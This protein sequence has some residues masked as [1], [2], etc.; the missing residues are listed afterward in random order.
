M[1]IVSFTA[2]GKIPFG[3]NSV[4]LSLWLYLHSQR[5]PPSSRRRVTYRTARIV[6]RDERDRDPLTHRSIVFD[7]AG[8]LFSW[9]RFLVCGHRHTFS[10]IHPFLV[11]VI[12]TAIC[13]ATVLRSFSPISSGNCA[14]V[15][16]PRIH[17][18]YT[19]V[20]L[21]FLHIVIELNYPAREH[22]YL[23]LPLQLEWTFVICIQ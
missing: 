17:V 16:S 23:V 3:C 5:I 8:N 6:P 1:L 18:V 10:M 15:E 7:R 14:T 13:F 22:N 11:L 2:H 9:P 20:R 21:L 12:I 19:I 4:T